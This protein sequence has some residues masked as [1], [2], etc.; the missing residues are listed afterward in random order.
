M[1]S[2]DLYGF[3]EMIFV[4]EDE[5]ILIIN[6]FDIFVDNE[7]VFKDDVVGKKEEDNFD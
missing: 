6:V 7:D 4:E 5:V 2:V 3:E 1:V